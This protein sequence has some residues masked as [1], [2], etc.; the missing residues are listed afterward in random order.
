MCLINR[1][2]IV[3]LILGPTSLLMPV[4][5]LILRSYLILGDFVDLCGG[6]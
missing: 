1:I 2:L 6:A 5:G 4:L 3:S